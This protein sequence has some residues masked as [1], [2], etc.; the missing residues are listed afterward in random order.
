MNKNKIIKTIFKLAIIVLVIASL[1]VGAYFL[2]KVLGFT[3]QDDIIRLRNQLGD[4]ILFWLVIGALQVFQVIFIPVSNQIITIPVAVVFHE[5]LWKVFLTSWIAIWLA[6]MILYFIGRWGGQKILNWVLGDQEQVN[7]CASWLNRGWIFYPLCMLLP[8][9]DDIVTC[10]AGVAKFKF[11]FVCACSLFTRAI[12]VACSV[13]GFG[14][15]TRFWWGWI[16]LCVGVI[17]LGLTT[18]LFWRR[19]GKK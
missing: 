10:L 13:W 19:Y 7:K 12:D 14:Y 18:L 2:L 9:P 4:S 3:T 16:I 1:A 6:T 15:L 5:E 17:I 11:Y 8:L